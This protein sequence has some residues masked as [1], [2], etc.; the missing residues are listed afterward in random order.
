VT[1]FKPGDRVKVVNFDSRF[2]AK[3]G[4]PQGMTGSIVAPFTQLNQSPLAGKFEWAVHLDDGVALPF[5]SYE[6][7]PIVPR[8]SQ[9]D[10]ESAQELL[11]DL[12]V[13]TLS[14]IA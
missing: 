12:D 14:A 7:A 4:K 8:P 9:A 11:A 13:Q 6:L 5:F 2:P 10:L 3:I 1:A